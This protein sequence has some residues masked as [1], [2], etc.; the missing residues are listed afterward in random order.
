MHCSWLRQGNQPPFVCTNVT[1][2]RVSIYAYLYMCPCLSFRVSVCPSV[3]LSVCPSVRLSVCP[4]VRLSVCPSA[5]LSVCP[6]VRLS[7]CPSV[8]LSVGPSV[9]LSACPFVRPASQPSRQPIYLFSSALRLS[10]HLQ[11]SLYFVYFP[12]PPVSA[13]LLPCTHACIYVARC[14][15]LRIQ[16]ALMCLHKG[17]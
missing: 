2:T 6:S 13:L 11:P 15:R 4:S 12:F 17:L 5:R 10:S 7:V 1:A 9:R 3:R 14:Q 8:H 16:Y